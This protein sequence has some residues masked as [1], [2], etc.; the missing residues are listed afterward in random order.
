MFR[1]VDKEK[2]FLFGRAQQ[3]INQ[4]PY[5]WKDRTNCPQ[6]DQPL[7]SVKPLVVITVNWCLLRLLPLRTGSNVQGEELA[8]ELLITLKDDVAEH[9][10]RFSSVFQQEKLIPKQFFRALSTAH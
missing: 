8:W 5:E 6:G 7:G 4:F 1:Y 10:H 9:R 2:I 3:I